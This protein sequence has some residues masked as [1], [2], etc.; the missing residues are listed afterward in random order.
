M[1]RQE[2]SNHTT[3]CKS[4]GRLFVKRD[5]EQLERYAIRYKTDRASTTVSVREKH[6]SNICSP[7][8]VV[9]VIHVVSSRFF[10]LQVLLGVLE[11]L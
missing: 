4:S 7:S 10:Y 2:E 11:P 8:T 1:F 9:H 3:S 6:L 5:Q